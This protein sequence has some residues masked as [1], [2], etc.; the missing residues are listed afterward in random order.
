M[1][2]ASDSIERV[3]VLGDVSSCSGSA[4]PLAVLGYVV[5]RGVSRDDPTAHGTLGLFG[6]GFLLWTFTKSVLH[7]G[8]VRRAND[9]RRFGPVASSALLAVLFYALFS[10]RRRTLGSPDAGTRLAIH[11]LNVQWSWLKKLKQHLVLP[12]VSSSLWATV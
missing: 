9:D 11:P 8:L 6:V 10:F 3:A 4:T 5:L 2:S 12:A 1:N 7:R